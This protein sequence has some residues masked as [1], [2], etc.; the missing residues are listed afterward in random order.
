MSKLYIYIYILLFDK[1]DVYT[2]NSW[3]TAMNLNPTQKIRP[4]LASEPKI[5]MNFKV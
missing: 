5:R 2:K 1:Y 3:F 4:F